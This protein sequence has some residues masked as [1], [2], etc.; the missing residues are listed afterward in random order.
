V[1][2][3]SAAI[4]FSSID[5]DQDQVFTVLA[6]AAHSPAQ[7]DALATGLKILKWTGFALGML[8][9][10]FC[11]VAL[12]IVL[13]IQLLRHASQRVA[14]MDSREA[15]D[16]VNDFGRAPIGDSQREKV[17]HS[18]NSITSQSANTYS[19]RLMARLLPSISRAR[20]TIFLN[21]RQ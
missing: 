12:K 16:N 1:G 18:V 13:G 17:S 14:G 21:F 2:I 5:G 6:S 9:G 10:W 15:E 7:L 8:I 19:P 4:V 20:M 3:Q 11:L